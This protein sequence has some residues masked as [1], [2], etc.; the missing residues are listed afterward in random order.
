MKKNK[1]LTFQRIFALLVLQA[2][3]S[4]KHYLKIFQKSYVNSLVM[5]SE[6]V[7]FLPLLTFTV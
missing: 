2:P 1:F 5:S 7:P 3:D 6:K 4:T